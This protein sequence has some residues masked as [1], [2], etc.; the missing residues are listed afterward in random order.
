M[1]NKKINLAEFRKLEVPETSTYRERARVLLASAKKVKK[2]S[3][4]EGYTDDKY[5]ASPKGIEALIG[6]GAKIIELNAFGNP[7]YDHYV[8]FGEHKFV[9]YTC[10]PVIYQ[11]YGAL[12]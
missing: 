4:A 1:K 2:G 11:I 8:V 10:E 7:T 6:A 9:A 12:R 5:L 3:R